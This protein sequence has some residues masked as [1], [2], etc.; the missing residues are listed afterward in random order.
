ML[1]HK[2]QSRAVTRIAV[3]VPVSQHQGTQTTTL[4]PTN[5]Q[6]TDPHHSADK[7]PT[8]PIADESPSALPEVGES[9][10]ASNQNTPEDPH[11]LRTESTS[12][13]QED[14]ESNDSVDYDELT[15]AELK[16]IYGDR[17]FS[18]S[19]YDKRRRANHISELIED[20]AG[21][22][23][24]EK[25]TIRWLRPELESRGQDSKRYKD[26]G[27]LVKALQTF[28]TQMLIDEPLEEDEEQE[29]GGHGAESTTQKTDGEDRANMES[30]SSEH[31][32][33]TAASTESGNQ[34]SQ[35]PRTPTPDPQTQSQH[36]GPRI[37]HQVQP[38]TLPRGSRAQSDP[39]P[40]IPRP[41]AESTARVT[42]ST[43]PS[44]TARPSRPF[45]R[46]GSGARMPITLRSQGLRR[47]R[48]QLSVPAALVRTVWRGVRD[49]PRS[50]RRLC[51]GRSPGQRRPAVARDWVG[52][53]Q[54]WIESGRC[55]VQ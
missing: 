47:P 29:D 19:H 42:K 13:G 53:V 38:T 39:L 28:D 10:G 43:S 49:F 32:A 45:Q 35:Q 12:G 44:P 17:G 2:I 14:G 24:Y 15:D 33:G 18:L 7:R 16:I 4:Q 23:P 22:V 51:R 46:G 6:S 3:Q 25:K 8:T 55:I 52:V 20:D 40:H 9:E 11:S 1:K 5:P 37:I 48:P 36:D 34:S 31:T 30:G 50:V 54:E 41:H 27:A 26:K 21:R